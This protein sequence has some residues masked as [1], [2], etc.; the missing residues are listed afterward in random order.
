MLSCNSMYPLPR[1]E[2]FSAHIHGDHDHLSRSK[3]YYQKYKLGCIDEKI[4]LLHHAYPKHPR[5]SNCAKQDLS[6]LDS[7]IGA[8]EPLLTSVI[9]H[10]LLFYYSTN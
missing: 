4:L 3:T 10:G 6:L 7:P 1:D 8:L 5:F 9:T 2:T